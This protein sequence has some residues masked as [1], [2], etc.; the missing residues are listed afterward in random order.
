MLAVGESVAR[1]VYIQ[2]LRFPFLLA[3]LAAMHALAKDVLAA[4]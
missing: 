4:S 3:V 2:S 1:G